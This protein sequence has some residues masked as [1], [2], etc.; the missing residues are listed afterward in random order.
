M[1]KGVAEGEN[2]KLVQLQG[3]KMKTR[4][5]KIITSTIAALVC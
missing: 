5:N 3:H 2:G 4:N 1:A